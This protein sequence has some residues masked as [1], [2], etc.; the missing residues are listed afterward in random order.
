VLDPGELGGYSGHPNRWVVTCHLAFAPSPCTHLHRLVFV[1][2]SLRAM[3]VFPL[4]FVPHR[5]IPRTRRFVF[6]SVASHLALDRR[7]EGQFGAWLPFFK[8][9]NYG[10]Q[11]WQSTV[12]MQNPQMPTTDRDGRAEGGIFLNSLCIL[13]CTPPSARVTTRCIPTRA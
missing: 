1:H 3:F 9:G 13:P 12:G 8:R 11:L 6:V 7:V 5:R 10:G 2:P 4:A